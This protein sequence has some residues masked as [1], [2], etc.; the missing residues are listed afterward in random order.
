MLYDKPATT[1]AQQLDL[2]RDRGMQWEDE[3]LVERWLQTVG[4]YRLSAYWLPFEQE[5][6]EGQ[7]RSKVFRPETRFEAIID[8][9]VFDRKL[10][11]IVMEA[12]ERIEIALR[13]R[14]TNRLSLASGAHAHIDR[15][16]FT[17][18]WQHAQMVAAL[19]RPVTSSQE[20]F[21][22]HYLEKYDAPYVPPLWIVTEL[23]T[24]G[25]LSRWLQCTADLKMKSAIAFDLGLPT[26]EA[27]EGTVQYLAYVR[28]IC[29]HHSRLWNRQTVKKLPTIKRFRRD[30]AITAK[31]QADNRIYNGLVILA[32]LLKHQ[33]TDTSY[34]TRV[35]DLVSDR[36]DWQL[37]SM[38]FPL[39]WQERPLWQTDNEVAMPALPN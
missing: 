31:G 10:R 17:E 15:A 1:I 37:R 12:I 26:R 29:A 39:D 8:I 11:L 21:V 2:L 7:T 35:A 13:A 5:P 4:Y 33:S 22:K 19:N 14:W 32:L 36:T 28:N 3:N 16:A 24:F 18:P 34:A 38:G 27:L 6:P 9:Y 30:I 23:L 25:E 20:R